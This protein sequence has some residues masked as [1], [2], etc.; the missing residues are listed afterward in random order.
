[1]K[2][3]KH[4]GAPLTILPSGDPHHTHYDEREATR[5]AYLEG[6]NA[7]K[8][9]R[10]TPVELFKE[11]SNREVLN[12]FYLLG[13]SLKSRVGVESVFHTM[14]RILPEDVR[15]AKEN[16]FIVAFRWLNCGHK[17]HEVEEANND[18]QRALLQYE[19]AVKKHE[20][21]EIMNDPCGACEHKGDLEHCLPFECDFKDHWVMKELLRVLVKNR[22]AGSES[23][24]IDGFFR[25]M[26]K[27]QKE[28]ELSKWIQAMGILSTLKPNMQIDVEDPVGMAKQVES[29]VSALHAA[30]W[31]EKQKSVRALLWIGTIVHA[32]TLASQALNVFPGG[33]QE[34]KK[35][36][37]AILQPIINDLLGMNVSDAMETL[38][39]V[40]MDL[41]S[42]EAGN[43]V[44]LKDVNLSFSPESVVGVGTSYEVK[45]NRP[46]FEE[47]ESDGE[48]KS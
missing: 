19:E 24:V 41:P 1:M 38:N 35:E 44:V 4:C 18:L 2:K 13:E 36:V 14:Y 32:A 31:L 40:K 5:S 7:G 30:L 11:Y 21:E 10:L 28:E 37:A 48:I 33:Q 42:V 17:E 16:V 25:I 46:A 26:E 15:M 43:P 23:R 6:F 27:K 29:E 22:K 45:V 8:K 3:C 20:G 9:V 12:F 39:Q 47:D 34:S